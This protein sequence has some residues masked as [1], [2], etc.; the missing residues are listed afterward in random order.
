MSSETSCP[1]GSGKLL[2]ACCAQILVDHSKALNAQQL[3]RSRYTAYTLADNEYL[4]ESWAAET[5]PA[6]LDVKDPAIQWIGLDIEGCGQGE[7]EDT[8]GTVTFTARF[9]SSGHHC[10]LHEQSR[11]IKRDNLWYYLDG[12][13]DSSTAK[14]GRNDPCPC[15]SGK[16]YKKCCR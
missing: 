4:L 11:F 10:K 13:S 1:C 15:G 9:L 12:K 3:M 5:R 2:S 8:A 14:A 6:E 16:K 7:K